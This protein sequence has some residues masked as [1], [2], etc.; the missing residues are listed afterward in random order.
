MKEIILDKPMPN[1]NQMIPLKD[2]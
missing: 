2:V 1:S